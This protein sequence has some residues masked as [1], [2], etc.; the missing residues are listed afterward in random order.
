MGRILRLPATPANAFIHYNVD[1][2]S[3]FLE[4]LD[5]YTT[6]ERYYESLPLVTAKDV[7]NRVQGEFNW[8]EYFSYTHWLD[9]IVFFEFRKFVLMFRSRN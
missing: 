6:V 5:R 7:H 8:R 4:K 9:H 2:I 1:T 3:H